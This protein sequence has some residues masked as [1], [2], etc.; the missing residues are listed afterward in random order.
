MTSNQKAQILEDRLIAFA[1][2]IIK[3]ADNL[4]KT[5]S[6]Q[7][8]SKQIVRSGSAPALLYGE[9]RGAQ[10]DKDFRHK[11]SI[12]LKELRET[13]INLKIILGAKYLSDHRLKDL[14]VE[15]NE[16]ISIFVATVRSLDKKLNAGRGL[17][18]RR[19]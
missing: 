2:R 12:A 8:F 13:Y 1:I 15:N 10:S 14:I 19:A 7:H 6:G 5:F 18:D 3:V 9:A 17:A 4:P 11:S 16:L